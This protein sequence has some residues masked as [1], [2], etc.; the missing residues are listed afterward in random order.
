M[1]I[2]FVP[3]MWQDHRVFDE[4]RSILIDCGIASVALP[5][6]TVGANGPNVGMF[7]DADKLRSAL[8]RV[9]DEGMEIVIV[10]HS[11]GGVVT[12]NAVKDL[13]IKQRAAHGLKGGITMILFLAAVVLPVGKSFLEVEDHPPWWNVSED[14]FMTPM[15]PL[16]I[17]YAD[18]E[19]DLAN[20]AVAGLKPSPFQAVADKSTYDPRDGSF[21]LGYIFCEDDR[22]LSIE[23][24]RA[25]FSQFPTGSFSASLKSS[26]S[27]FLSMPDKLAHTIVEAVDH[28]L[29]KKPSI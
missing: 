3:G 29:G 14:G 1:P 12:S 8:I 4:V 9:I 26:H 6:V 10:A 13:G 7:S 22:A 17:F 24:Q 18:V 15:T 11:Y 2:L 27:P 28:V 25:M 5:L 21:E 20:R 23:A 16:D 19:P